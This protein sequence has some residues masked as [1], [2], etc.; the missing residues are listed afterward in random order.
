M[1]DQRR[2]MGIGVI[3]QPDI[4]FKKKF[5][6]TFKIIGFCNNEKN[7]VPE[8]FIKT[9]ARPTWTTEETQIDFLNGRT[10]I[11]SKSYWDTIDVTYEDVAHVDNLPLFN[12][13]ATVYDFTDPINLRQGIKRDWDATGVLNMYDGCGVLL[14]QWQLR[15][16][17][18]TS[19]NF[20]DL[21]YESADNAEISLTLRYSDVVYR[22]FCPDFIPAGCC[23]GCP[24]PPP[25]TQTD[26]DINFV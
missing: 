8:H 11:P 26:G 15:H 14:E 12:W 10:W 4:T 1:A 7:E 3:G 16:M 22:S 19:V 23:S 17:F 13:L 20:N 2:A 9:V 6:F 24:A 5:R 21:A 18:P 25:G